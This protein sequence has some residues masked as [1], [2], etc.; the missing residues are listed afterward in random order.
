MSIQTPLT[1]QCCTALCVGKSCLEANSDKF[2]KSDNNTYGIALQ[3]LSGRLMCVGCRT[4]SS[5]FAIDYVTRNNIFPT[6]PESG[7]TL[8]DTY[9][10]SPLKRIFTNE[11]RTSVHT[12]TPKQKYIA[13]T[14]MSEISKSENRWE[15]S[16]F[17]VF[18]QLCVY[19]KFDGRSSVTRSHGGH[20]EP[21]PEHWTLLTI[22]FLWGVCPHI[23]NHV[24][25][26][27]HISITLK[28]N[29]CIEETMSF[30]KMLCE[31]IYDFSKN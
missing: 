19:S 22:Y 9:N 21:I 28:T 23:H 13:H 20:R 30:W 18:Q 31:H 17:A 15:E 16:V 14:V 25:I 12:Q 27:I 6:S 24:Y 29:Y 10:V 5:L 4:L 2:I 7:G 26:Y 11:M 8:S 1:P 3:T